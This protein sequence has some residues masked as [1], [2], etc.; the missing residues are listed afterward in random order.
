MAILREKP[1]I[2]SNKHVQKRL[3]EAA[4]ELFCENGFGATSVRDLTTRAGC[5]VA[6]VNYYFGSKDNLYEEVF[7]R[8]LITIT[9]KRIASI[10]NLMS[11]K[12][13]AIVLEELL[14][15]FADSFLEPLLDK[16]SGRR[17]IKLMT[18]EIIDPH[19][20]RSLF[21]E[22][23]IVPT[24]GTMQQALVKVC[25]GL[26]TKAINMCIFSLIGQLLHLIR[27]KEMFDEDEQF[28]TLMFKFDQ[29]IEHVVEFSAAGIRA[30]SKGK[31]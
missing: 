26:E 30:A 21:I 17:F 20:P 10:K 19:L 1:N 7:R 8:Q 12:E 28:G 24:I 18:R 14:R 23:M 27:L 5:N 11:R 6:A 13:P 9:D 31:D 25:P 29:V 15:V 3:L 22:K 4:E 16:S 2:E